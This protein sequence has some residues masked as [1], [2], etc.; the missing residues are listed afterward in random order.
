MKKVL[1]VVSILVLIILGGICIVDHIRMNNNEEVLFSTWGKKYS[2][3]LKEKKESEKIVSM[4]KKIIE[5]IIGN[6][7]GLMQGAQ[8]I[9]L[10][11]KSLKAPGE[12]LNNHAELTEQQEVELLEYCKNYHEQVKNQSLEELR[13]SGLVEENNGFIAIEGVLIRV[14]EI[15]KLKEN[16]AIMEVQTFRTGL[17]AVMVKYELKYRK[18]E[19]AIENKGMAIS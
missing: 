17:G 18:G 11:I 8:Y 13:Q 5:D 14:I 7:R 2:P 12:D 10:D 6:S 15:E 3:P 19:W 4:Y 1:L 9:S 16:K